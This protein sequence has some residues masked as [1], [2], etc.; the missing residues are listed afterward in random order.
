MYLLRIQGNM[1]EG[2]TSP[3]KRGGLYIH[4]PFC[5]SKCFYCDFYSRP[6][7]CTEEDF[8]GYAEALIHEYN[9]RREDYDND[10]RWETVYIGGG[11]PSILPVKHLRRIVEGLHLRERPVEFTIEANPEDVSIPWI[12]EIQNLGINRISMGIQSFRDS[13]L[14]SIGRIHS[15]ARAVEAIEALTEAGIDYSLDLIYGLPGQS[16]HDWESNLTKLLSFGPSHFSAYLLSYEPGTR[17]YYKLQKGEVDEATEE[18]ATEMYEILC[19]TAAENGYE[20][21]EI[22]N[23]ANPGKR[24]IHNSNY[25]KNL[26]YLGLGASAHSYDGKHRGYNPP[27]VK[28]Y[29]SALKTGKI[30]FQEEK[31]SE[32]ER[33]NDLLIISFRTADGLD[34]RRLDEYNERNR[35]MEKISSLTKSGMLSINA[36]GNIIIP[37]NEWLRSDSILRDLII[38]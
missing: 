35:I 29:I 37:E 14:R 38:A 26:P 15:S 13:E 36:K 12:R 25:W 19:H 4:I 34:L 17:L 1:L 23:F 22:S 9:L 27:D 10:G 30:P 2:L 33:L 21:Y 11:T 32:T 20:H 6:C 31:E 28:N 5:H 18:T 7:K 16:L 24:A 8:D 3:K